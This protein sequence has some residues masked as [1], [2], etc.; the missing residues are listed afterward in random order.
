M[1][2][3]LGHGRVPFARRRWHH[4]ASGLP[5]VYIKEEIAMRNQRYLLWIALALSGAVVADDVSNERIPKQ[6]LDAGKASFLANCA[7]CHQ[8]EGT[9]VPTT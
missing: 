5:R 9:P 1:V 8:P 4:A 2:L 6:G 3:D 7:A